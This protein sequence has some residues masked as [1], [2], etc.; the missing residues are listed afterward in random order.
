MAD[1]IVQGLFGPTAQQI[2]QE[3]AA[4]GYSQDLQAVRL[5]PRQQANLAI[6]Q[7]GRAF[8]S[9]VMA[10]LLG[11]QDP[12]LQKAQMAQQLASQFNTTTPEGLTQYAQAL[13]QNG[14]PDL[15]QMAMV[16]VQDM[17]T[18]AQT[19]Q[20][21]GLTMKTQEAALESSQ[22]KL[23]QEK[24]LR[25]ALEALSPNA[26]IEERLALLQQFGG[27]DVQATVLGRMLTAQEKAAEN[28]GGT[29]PGS[30]GKAGAYRD[31][32][33]TVYGGAEMKPIRQEFEASQRLL[34]TLNKV[35]AGD[36]KDSESFIDWTTKAEAKTLASSKTLAAQSKIA[37]NQLLA[38]IESLPPGS[39]S[40]KDMKAA[41]KDF[42]GYSDPESLRQWVNRTKAKLQSNLEAQADNFGFKQRIT[43]SGDLSFK[44]KGTAPQTK[45]TSTDDDLIKKYLNK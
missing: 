14:A 33:G 5:D 20:A 42:P 7:G 25:A 21:Q 2:Q 35:S 26:S 28:Q 27:P 31:S 36:I 6:R 39:A 10:P 12:E 17:Q 19:M 9:Q 38:Q 22:Y 3:R 1:S 45:A 13:A 8:G 44:S 11:V 23:A 15:A 29:G 37:A 18:K 34:D 40:D 30:V 24:K 16:R 41:M 32:Y 43:S 4:T